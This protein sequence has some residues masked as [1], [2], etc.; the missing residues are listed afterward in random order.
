MTVST[1]T[2]ASFTSI[3]L[4]V[5][6]PWAKDEHLNPVPVKSDPRW[7]WVR[8]YAINAGNTVRRSLAKRKPG[9]TTFRLDVARLRGTHGQFL[10]QNLRERIQSADILLFDIGS[11]DGSG[12]NQNVLIETGMA[13]ALAASTSKHTFILKPSRLDLPSDLHGFLVT[14]YEA[15]A[16]GK[17]LKLQDALGFHAALRSAIRRVAES[18]GMSGPARSPFVGDEQDE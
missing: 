7:R 4:C 2:P 16:R 3:R 11:L 9:S 13:L 18:R 17:G 6:Y 10:L 8:D 1:A 12:F 5:G 15:K 14:N